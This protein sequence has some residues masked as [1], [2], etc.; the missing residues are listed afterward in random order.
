MDEAM[1]RAR[2]II[3]TLTPLESD[4]G[5]LCEGACCQTD[6]DGNGGVYL[7]PGEEESEFTWGNISEDA[8]GKMLNCESGCDREHRPFA[9]RIFPLTPVQNA[10]GKWTVRMDARARMMCPLYRSGARGLNPAFTKAVI[11]ALREI[12]K[13]PEGNAF[14]MRWEELE[15]QYRLPF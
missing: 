3:G 9:C 1:K 14:L 2:E 15:K 11:L 7:F 12:A 4:C 8:F 10:Q 6:A 13:T 5:L